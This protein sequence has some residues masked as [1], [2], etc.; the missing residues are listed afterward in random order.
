MLNS[1]DEF[2]SVCRSKDLGGDSKH[3]GLSPW[4][5]PWREP[6]DEPEPAAEESLGETEHL[7]GSVRKGGCNGMWGRNPRAV[8]PLGGTAL[9]VSALGNFTH[10]GLGA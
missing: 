4:L 8:L 3:A 5:P 2:I 9:L 6:P 1:C 7:K 10:E